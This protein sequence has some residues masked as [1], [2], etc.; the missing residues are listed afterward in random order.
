MTIG[1]A[2]VS[3]TLSLPAASVAPSIAKAGL[4]VPSEQ[5]DT[6]REYDDPEPETT[7]THPVAVPPF[8]KSSFATPV[9]FSENVS[10]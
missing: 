9:T 6:A 5:L 4:T 2:E 10:E 3:A 1:E 8:E 7:K